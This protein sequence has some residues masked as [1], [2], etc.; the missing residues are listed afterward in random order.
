ME[1]LNLPEFRLPD[2]VTYIRKILHFILELIIQRFNHSSF[3]AK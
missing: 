1:N 2:L 3:L